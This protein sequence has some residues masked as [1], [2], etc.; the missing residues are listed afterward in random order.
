MH[1]QLCLCASCLPELYIHENTAENTHKGAAAH[2]C[3]AR[4][5]AFWAKGG[6]GIKAAGQ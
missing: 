1:V 5:L 4:H 3:H 6:V 2:C